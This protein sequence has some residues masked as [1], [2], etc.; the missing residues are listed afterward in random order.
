[1]PTLETYNKIMGNKTLGEV[2]KEQSDEIMEATWD[3]DINTRTGYL[4]DWYHD[5]H[6]Q[7]LTNLYPAKDKN[8]MPISIKY[9]KR[10]NQSFGSDQVAY[11]IQLKPSQKCNVG[12]YS[13]AFG[14]YDTTFP[15]GLYIDIPD[16][17]GKYNRWLIVSKADHYTTQ[18]STF[19]ILP[20]NKVFQ[21]VHE[22]K[23]YN[24]AG[25][26]RS[27]S[28]NASGVSEVG[29]MNEVNAQEAFIVPLNYDTEKIYYNQR[30]IIDSFVKTEPLTWKIV[31]IDR[32][33]YNGCVYSAIKQDLFNEHTDYIEKDDDGNVIGMWAD[34]W[35]SEIE[36]TTPT[37][38][39]KD[40]YCKISYNSLTPQI[41]VGGSYRLLDVV[42]YHIEPSVG[43]WSFSVN[44]TEEPIGNLLDTVI[45]GNEVKVKFIGD[46][47][48][49]GHILTIEYV[50]GEMSDKLELE[51]VGL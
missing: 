37:P 6:K 40:A 39:P 17:K 34:Y 7:E 8:K 46:D 11:Y 15:I 24:V 23:K 51:I 43:S 1:M 41:R 31:K 32:N 20:C 30:I 45:D 36:P 9:M 18:F 25:A 19:F 29:I 50:N 47:M 14:R 2:R 12:Y 4:Y 13:D 42:F 44:D 35:K 33:T 27:K 10:G 22:G 28:S 48:Y 38:P 3:G 21:Y 16:N 26:L 5:I 49:I